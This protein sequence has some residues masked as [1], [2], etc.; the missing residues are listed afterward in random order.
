MNSNA[1]ADA[2]ANFS[3]PK[4]GSR[5]SARPTAVALRE[6][7]NAIADEFARFS[8][9]KFG[10]NSDHHRPT[11]AAFRETSNTLNELTRALSTSSSRTKRAYLA[12]E[13]SIRELADF[14]LPAFSS[15]SSPVLE[16]RRSPSGTGTQIAGYASTPAL[17]KMNEIIAAG[18][19]GSSLK[20]H[21][22][23]GTAPY[24]FYAHAWALGSGNDVPVGVWETLSEDARGLKAV[25]RLIPEVRQGAEILALLRNGSPLSLSVGFRTLKDQIINKIRVIQEVDLLEISIVPFAASRDTGIQITGK[26]YS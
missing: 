19:F 22:S 2:F 14:R 16:L 13:Q 10:S 12:L 3:L 4:F 11:A 15:S 1:F 26:E 5:S 8:L 9:P 18:A 7:S 23:E 21:Q 6:A 25:G 17:D 20:K 24:M